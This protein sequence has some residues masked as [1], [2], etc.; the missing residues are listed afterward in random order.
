MKE[1]PPPKDAY[2]IH[3]TNFVKL[4]ATSFAW[5]VGVFMRFLLTALYPLTALIINC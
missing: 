3:R 4:C 5:R 1:N 2:S